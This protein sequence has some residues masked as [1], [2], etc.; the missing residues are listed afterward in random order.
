[1]TG[2]VIAI[3]NVLSNEIDETGYAFAMRRSTDGG[4]TWSSIQTI[5]SIPLASTNYLSNPTAVVDAET[6]DVFFLFCQNSDQV[7]VMHSSDDGLTGSNPTNIPSSVKVTPGNNPNPDEFPDDPWGW[8]AVGP[9]H[10]I[11]L[12]QGDDAGRLVVAADHRLST[13][14]SGLSW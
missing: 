12:T 1:P 14:R 4:N 13:D 8:Y 5:Y 6:G 7:M 10:G 3:A 9:S 11:Q 2:T